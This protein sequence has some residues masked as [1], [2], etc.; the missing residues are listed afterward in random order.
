[1]PQGR[2]KLAM[3]LTGCQVAASITC[4]PLDRPQATRSWLRRAHDGAHHLPGLQVDDRHLAGDLGFVVVILAVLLLRRAALGAGLG[5]LGGPAALSTRTGFAA[6]RG[7]DSAIVTKQNASKAVRE[8]EYAR[9]AVVH[10]IAMG[11]PDALHSTPW[12]IPA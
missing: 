10:A 2:S 7:A 5:G 1:M 9:G 3:V 12:R 6:F 11:W 8:A 4:T